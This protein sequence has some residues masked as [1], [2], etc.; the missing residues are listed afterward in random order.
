LILLIQP[1]YELHPRTLIS[2]LR[3]AI[4]AAGK[5][6]RRS[7]EKNL[8]SLGPDDF[9]ISGLKGIALQSQASEF[10]TIC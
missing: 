2:K 1:G 4:G 3:Q 9:H 5:S 8:K 6:I 7:V 10:V